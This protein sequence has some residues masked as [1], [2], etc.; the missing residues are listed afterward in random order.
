MKKLFLALIFLAI[1]FALQAQKHYAISPENYKL[2]ISVDYKEKKLT[3]ICELTLTNNSNQSVDSIS[4]LLYR[5]MKV[6]DVTDSNNEVI[7][8]TQHVT[9]FD[10]FGK[11]Q[12]NQILV[13]KPLH[14][15]ESITI[16]LSYNGYL[17]GY[18]ET[19]MSY[20]KDRISPLFTF[21]RFDAYAYPYPCLPRLSVLR[22]STSAKFDYSLTVN[23][24][25]NLVA[26]CGGEFAAHTE[27]NGVATY[28]YISK[29]PAW[30]MDI[31][32]ADY[33][34]IE[35]NWINVFYYG[36][37]EA[38]R[39]ITDKGDDCIKLYKQ[40]WG[41][42]QAYSGLTVVETEEGSGGQTDETTILLPSEAFNKDN[43]FEYLYHELSHLWNV[44][45]SESQGMSP[46]WEEGL[47]SFC[48]VLVAEKL[49][50]KSE[51]YVKKHTDAYIN[52]FFDRVESDERLKNISLIDY[53]NRNMTDFSYTQAMIMFSVL[54]YWLGDENFNNL[55][56]GFYKNYYKTGASTRTFT[57]YCIKHGKDKRLEGFFEEWIYTTR[58]IK[59]LSPDATVDKIVASY[60]K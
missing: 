51:G 15:K 59:H 56:G 16:K 10:D 22:L 1:P 29:Q 26:V 41:D 21:I 50:D 20:I 5:L 53:G 11:L 25:D 4:F 3:G 30:R 23:V 33:K 60:K 58:Y 57:E 37:E 42:L 38:A 40:W 35:S 43:G 17:L 46:R 44:P 6:T 34:K 52:W 31:A 39:R 13:Y 9:E 27:N 49:G 12:V 8:Y 48:Q 54:Y 45:I 24:P 2:T 18:A 36:N 55:I 28:K 47:A 19:G 32:I 7:P 14:P